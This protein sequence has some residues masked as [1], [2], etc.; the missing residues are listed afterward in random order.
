[1]LAGR[2]VRILAGLLALLVVTVAA[3]AF[4][5]RVT[6]LQSVSAVGQTVQVGATSPSMSLSGPGQLDLFGQSLPTQ[7]SFDGPVRPR[8]VL[9]RITIN[10]QIA[11]LLKRAGPS[12]TV[13][14]LGAA[15][16]AGWQR[17]FAW[18]IGFVAVGAVVL[19][20]ALAGLVRP[21][22]RRA[23][24]WVVVAVLVA[25]AANVGGILWTARSAPSVL[26]GVDS[27]N[28]LVGRA[29]A[30]P[31]PAGPGGSQPGVAAVVLGDSTA[32]APGN[33]LVASPSR[34][35]KACR[36]SSD[37]YA[38]Q[39]ARVNSWVV[40]NLACSSATIPEGILGPQRVGSLSIPAQLAVARRAVDARAI[41]LSVGA[42][43]VNWSVLV[44]LCAMSVTCD[45]AASTAY[46]QSLLNDFT[47]SYYDL[48]AQLAALPNHPV[49]VVNLYYVPFDPRL[50]CLDQVGLTGPKQK[51]LLDRL[52]ALNAVLAKGAAVFGFRVGQPDFTGHEICTA[53]PY[54]Q[55]LS[56]PAPFHPTTAGELAIALA[57]QQALG[58]VATSGGS[59]SLPL[60]LVS[61]LSLLSPVSLVSLV[62]LVSPAG[63]AGSAWRPSGPRSG[64]SATPR[65]QPPR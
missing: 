11:G 33:P 39:L 65:G 63:P 41:L 57:D 47:T 60:S 22:W 6:P 46:F 28:A 36:R 40:E 12:A 3:I 4:A 13:D 45:D 1:M 5:L 55:G 17:Y 24:L 15:L 19:G 37:S 10:A 51:V 59:S 14:G 7:A 29:P 25:E 49:V 42:D 21:P 54:V 26:A 20:V 18:E 52:S 64:R 27:L 23:G 8:L 38:V 32:A 62:S 53:Q 43:D 48:L 16:A 2:V 44:R 61:P 30:A 58:R 56:D 9:T 50:G 35:D 34:Q 31:I